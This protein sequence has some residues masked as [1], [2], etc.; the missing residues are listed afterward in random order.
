MLE[1]VRFGFYEVVVQDV[2]I[3]WLFKFSKCVVDD[4][5]VFDHYAIILIGEDPRCAQFGV[6]YKCIFDLV[7]WCFLGVFFFD[8][9]F[10]MVS[11]E[12]WIGE[13]RFLL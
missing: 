13:D 10:V 8:A 7:V 1:G 5:E 2:L 4:Q 9:V 11:V 3:C 12:I 6:E